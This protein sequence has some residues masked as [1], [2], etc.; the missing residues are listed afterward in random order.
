MK[1]FLN[2]CASYYWLFLIIAIVLGFGV[3]GYFVD[4]NTNILAI[5]KKKKALLAKSMNI[6]E[7][8][9][10]IKD[11]NVSLGGMAGLDNAQNGNTVNNINNVSQAVN[12]VTVNQN[13]NSV[14]SNVTV[15]S[16]EEDLTVPFKLDL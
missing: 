15:P 1:E 11:K 3:A 10:Q 7:I 14:N 9:N 13:V 8:K 4:Y 6:N 12:A 5:E 2:F 16:A